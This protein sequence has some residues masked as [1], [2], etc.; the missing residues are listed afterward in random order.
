MGQKPI[1]AEVV[2]TTEVSST[3]TTLFAAD[4]RSGPPWWCFGLAGITAG[5]TAVLVVML[6]RK[7]GKSVGTLA[8]DVSCDA[9]APHVTP[10]PDVRC[11]APAPHVRCPSRI[12]AL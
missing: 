10:A 9:P 11:A 4:I 8:P 12:V 7:T 2:T 1:S 3:E 6:F 5:G